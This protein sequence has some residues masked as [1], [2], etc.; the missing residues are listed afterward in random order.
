M[1]R[2]RPV[3]DYWNWPE[4]VVPYNGDWQK[5]CEA[6]KFLRN[7]LDHDAYHILATKE[8]EQGPRK[9]WAMKYVT[10]YHYRIKDFAVASWF[11]L[12]YA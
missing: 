8:Y 5:D 6:R 7:N 2:G 12:K 3:K 4:I 1:K 10:A 11:S 9:K